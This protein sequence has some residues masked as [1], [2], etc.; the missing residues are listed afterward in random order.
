M[1]KDLVMMRYENGYSSYLEVL[2]VERN[3]FRIEIAFIQTRKLVS[4][5]HQSSKAMGS[6]W[7]TALDEKATR[8]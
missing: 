2:D 5:H 4:S 6:L 3:L 7:F 8:G 1:Y